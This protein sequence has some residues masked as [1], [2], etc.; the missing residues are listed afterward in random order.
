[1][2]HLPLPCRWKL[3]LGLE[4]GFLRVLFDQSWIPGI[5]EDPYMILGLIWSLYD[6]PLETLSWAVP[7]KFWKE[8]KREGRRKEFLN[9]TEIS[10]GNF[11]WTNYY[12]SSLAL[13][14]ASLDFSHASHDYEFPDVSQID[15]PWS[16]SDLTLPRIPHH[17]SQSPNK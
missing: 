12:S 8:E 16:N 15:D 17:K 2:G 4:S 1:M 10:K 11:N 14:F 13:D 7:G 3:L 6:A 5:P 9:F